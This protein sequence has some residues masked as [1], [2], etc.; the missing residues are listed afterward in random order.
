M[1]FHFI[2]SYSVEPVSNRL[3]PNIRINLVHTVIFTFLVILIRII[4]LAIK[5]VI[6]W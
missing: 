4:R 1:V 5:S 2:C 3:H 6:I